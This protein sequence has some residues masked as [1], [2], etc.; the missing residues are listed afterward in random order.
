MLHY[1]PSVGEGSV[2]VVVVVGSVVDS[3]S[4]VESFPSIKKMPT[5]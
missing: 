5:I 1:L 4:G 2:V 3:Q